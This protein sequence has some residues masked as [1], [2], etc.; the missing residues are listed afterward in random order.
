MVSGGIWCLLVAFL[1]CMFWL[2]LVVLHF[3]FR[4]F[5]CGLF[6]EMSF[7]SMS[8]GLCLFIVYGVY[9]NIFKCPFFGSVAYIKEIQFSWCLPF[10]GM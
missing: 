4:P 6:A 3:L 2:S 7:T 10:V 9:L 1:L 5:T 8:S